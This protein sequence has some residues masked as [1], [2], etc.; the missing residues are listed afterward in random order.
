VKVNDWLEPEEY[1]LQVGMV[2]EYAITLFKKQLAKNNIDWSSLTNID[3]WYSHD[4]QR[5]LL[6]AEYNGKT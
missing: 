3:V 1:P 6:T 2:K 4:M 5:Y